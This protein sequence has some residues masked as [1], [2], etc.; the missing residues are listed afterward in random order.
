MQTACC[1]GQKKRAPE[2]TAD[3]KTI[4]RIQE[5]IIRA[6]SKELK[7]Y[8]KDKGPKKNQQDSIKSTGFYK[9]N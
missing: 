4:I 2:T 8:K 1:K 7:I 9:I 6:R 5:K 3:L